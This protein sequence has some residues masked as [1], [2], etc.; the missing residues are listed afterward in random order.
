VSVSERSSQEQVPMEFKA[1]VEKTCKAGTHSRATLHPDASKK[2]VSASL[3]GMSDHERK[4]VQYLEVHPYALHCTAA[5]PPASML[6]A[7]GFN[8]GSAVL[9]SIARCQ[10]YALNSADHTHGK[11]SGSL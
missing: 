1:S 11:H 9:Q 2:S 5:P 4:S 7:S 10:S 3:L 8:G 6:Q